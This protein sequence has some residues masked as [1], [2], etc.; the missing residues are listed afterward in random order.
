MLRDWTQSFTID[1]V[2]M[3]HFTSCTLSCIS[4]SPRLKLLEGLDSLSPEEIRKL[5]RSSIF[6]HQIEKILQREYT[7]PGDHTA[8]QLL[9]RFTKTFDVHPTNKQAKLE[10]FD[11][12]RMTMSNFWSIMRRKRQILL[13]QKKGPFWSAE[14]IE[15]D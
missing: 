15:A 7:L 4:I 5:G 14:E 3:P 10:H 6:R 11:S 13:K 8:S 12:T 9:L 1:T 2:T